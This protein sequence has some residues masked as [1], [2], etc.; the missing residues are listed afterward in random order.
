MSKWVHVEGQE[1][2]PPVYEKKVGRPPKARRKEPHEVQGRT[3]SKLSKHG[4]KIHCSHCK[5]EG[6]NK[7]SCELRK[8][9]FPPLPQNKEQPNVEEG[10]QDHNF[11]D[12]P[13]SQ[14]EVITQVIC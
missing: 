9:G 3:G 8:A 7:A 1:I 13:I 14:E 2:L 12:V 11:E 6:H 4:V 10:R 5:G